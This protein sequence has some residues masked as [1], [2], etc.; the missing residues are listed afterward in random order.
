MALSAKTISWGSRTSIRAVERPDV[1]N[2]TLKDRAGEAAVQLSLCARRIF[3]KR[4]KPSFSVA[5]S[6]MYC[7]LSIMQKRGG[8]EAIRNNFRACFGS[9]VQMGNRNLLLELESFG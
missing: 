1:V 3:R 5:G 2:K 8:G 4:I 6:S 9:P 7:R